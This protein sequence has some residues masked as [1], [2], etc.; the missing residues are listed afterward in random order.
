M[1][2]CCKSCFTLQ[3]SVSSP[4]RSASVLRFR[5]V[6]LQNAFFEQ[7][8]GQDRQRVPFRE[9]RVVSRA[10]PLHPEARGR[11]SLDIA[12][13]PLPLTTICLT[14]SPMRYDAS[15]RFRCSYLGN[16][17]HPF[18]NP[19]SC[20]LIEL[21]NLVS[22]YETVHAAVVEPGTQRSDLHGW[23]R[24]RPFTTSTERIY[25][26][27]PEGLLRLVSK[28]GKIMVFWI[29]SCWSGDSGLIPLH[30]SAA[31]VLRLL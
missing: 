3:S 30:Q 22:K 31:C 5:L 18:R 19:A 21:S 16:L 26:I 2:R 1:S 7:S 12:R 11:C 4:Q 9:Q 27:V 20:L 17:Q 23:R 8:S 29:W 24:L 13:R 25:F 6:A 10:L 28:R 15:A 14:Q